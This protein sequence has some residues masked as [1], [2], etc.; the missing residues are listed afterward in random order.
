MYFYYLL[1]IKSTPKIE[2]ISLDNVYDFESWLAPQCNTIFQHHDYSE[3]RIKRDECGVVRIYTQATPLDDFEMSRGVAVFRYSELVGG[4]S[5]IIK[6]N[7]ISVEIVGSIKTLTTPG[8]KYNI[9][10][11]DEGIALSRDVDCMLQ[12]E[13]KMVLQTVILFL[14]ILSY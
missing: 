12:Y 1:G 8:N 7:P 6:G 4:P 9:L 5:S 14:I 11:L 2:G 3:F 13:P 10:T